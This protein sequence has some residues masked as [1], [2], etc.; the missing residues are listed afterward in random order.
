VD[1][2]PLTNYSSGYSYSVNSPV[3]THNINMFV[4]GTSKA[5]TAILETLLRHWP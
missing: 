4:Y 5:S 2:F 3:T 1:G